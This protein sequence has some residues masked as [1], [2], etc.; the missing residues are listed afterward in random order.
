MSRLFIVDD[1]PIIRLGLS[2][3]I[4]AYGRIGTI[5]AFEDGSI[6]WEHVLADPP[7]IVITDIRM[8]KLDG[9]E[10]CK[11]ISQSQ[12]PTKII[13][14]SGYNDFSYAQKCISYNVGEYLLKPV[15]ERELYPVL[16]KVLAQCDERPVSFSRFEHWIEELEEAMWMLDEHK[17]NEIFQAN[18]LAFSTNWQWARDGLELLARKLNMRG[19]YSFQF[20]SSYGEN[21]V[22]ELDPAAA[23][24]RQLQD[25]VGQLKDY[26]GG[27]QLNIL[28]ASL[29]FMEEHLCEELTLESVAKKLGVSPSYFSSYFKRMT[30]E[31]FVQ[32]RLR[33]RIDRAKALLAIPH[34]KVIDVMADVGYENYPHFSRSFKKI[35]GYSPTEYRSSIGIKS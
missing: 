5:R 35:T 4:E 15:T 34:Y 24:E 16:D 21:H 32:Y 25:W 7:E 6:A 2:T 27:N 18:R 10:L 23:F 12:L 29:S 31:T 28:E 1:E 17:V 26:R 19:S 13:V 30:S 22:A 9:L 8:P 11:R 14:L 33:R 3:M 20:A